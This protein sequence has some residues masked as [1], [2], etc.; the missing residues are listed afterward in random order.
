MPLDNASVSLESSRREI[1]LVV[2][3][4]PL[5]EVG[6]CRLAELREGARVELVE[7]IG[8]LPFSFLFSALDGEPL[9]TALA[10]GRI[11]S[12]VQNDAIGALIPRLYVASHDHT[13][14]SRLFFSSQISLQA[15][16]ARIR[17]TF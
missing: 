14:F 6:H 2:F 9:L 7:Y 13:P 12:Q 8:Q 1:R 10:S 15:F 3:Q 4:P 5:Q 16:L 11:S 17:D